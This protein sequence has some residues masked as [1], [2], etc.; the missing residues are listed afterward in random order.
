MPFKKKSSEDPLNKCKL[1]SPGAGEEQEYVY[2]GELDNIIGRSALKKN[3]PK[4]PVFWI[5]KGFV[6]IIQ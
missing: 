6:L 2:K 4:Y 3:I 5:E 1:S